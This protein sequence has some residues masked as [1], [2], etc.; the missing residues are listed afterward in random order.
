MKWVGLERMFL[1]AGLGQPS[2][3]FGLWLSLWAAAMGLLAGIGFTV[4]LLIAELAYDTRP[5]LL[6]DAKVGIL[7]GTFGSAILATA[8]LGWRRRSLASV[9]AEDEADADGDGIPDVYERD[10]GT[11]PSGGAR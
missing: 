8:A 5:D 3:R 11:P 1:R 7:A 2:E 9:I 6:M 4:S 10:G